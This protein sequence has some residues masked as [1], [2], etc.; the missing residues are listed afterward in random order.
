M[1]RGNN[2]EQK[3]LEGC[4][5]SSLTL[6]EQYP[7]ETIAIP[8]IST[9]V[10]GF[11]KTL[12]AQIAIAAVSDYLKNNHHLKKVIFVTYDEDNYK[13]YTTKLSFL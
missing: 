12:A 6:T 8:N 11:P 9:G 7:I 13:L 3:L 2:N 10:Y 4:Y 1:D 5:L